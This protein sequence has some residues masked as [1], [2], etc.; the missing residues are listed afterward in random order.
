MG[1][2]PVPKVVAGNQHRRRRAVPLAVNDA[3][4]I[5]R[6]IHFSFLSPL[7]GIGWVYIQRY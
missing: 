6:W 4:E 3:S 1:V 7:Y 5:F 2:A